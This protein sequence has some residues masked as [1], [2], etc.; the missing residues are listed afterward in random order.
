MSHK[1]IKIFLNMKNRF[2]I[3]LIAILSVSL[4]TSCEKETIK[5]IKVVLTEPAKFATDIWPL[6]NNNSCVNCHDGMVF[7]ATSA[8]TLITT[9]KSANLVT[10]PSATSKLMIRVNLTP[11][12]NGISNYSAA[13]KAKIASWIDA[14]ALDN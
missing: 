11:A 5:P 1:I 10:K 8:T 4:F 2:I 6:F 14:G 13:D 12:H 3:L 7:D 9:L